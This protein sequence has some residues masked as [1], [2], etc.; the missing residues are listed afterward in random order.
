MDTLAL[1]RDHDW[2][3]PTRWAPDRSV[4]N[5]VINGAPISGGNSNILYFHHYFGKMIQFDEHIF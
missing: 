3:Q 1:G 2:M 5:G 4:I